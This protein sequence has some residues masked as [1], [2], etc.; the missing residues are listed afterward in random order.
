[1][2]GSQ[3]GLFD[4]GDLAEIS[5][6]G[7]RRYI[8]R[9]GRPPRL[10]F[11][12]LNPSTAD[13]TRDDPT[14]RRCKGFAERLGFA[15]VV[16]GN[17]FSW[18]ATRPA[19]LLEALLV[20]E[21]GPTS[22]CDAALRAVIAESEALVFAWGASCERSPEAMKQ[23]ADVEGLAGALGASPK[24]LGF[25]YAGH[26]RHPLYASYGESLSCYPRE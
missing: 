7:K 20:G 3:R 12:M 22:A 26:P 5:G 10:G 15:G 4:V 6:D 8:L 1:M 19:A 18:R 2:R 13:A 11:I 16:I 9:R 23:I 14:V 25:T 21:A 17:L 24:A